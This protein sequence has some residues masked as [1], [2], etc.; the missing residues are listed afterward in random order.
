MPKRLEHVT[1]D[2][3]GFEHKRMMDILFGIKKDE[4]LPPIEIEIADPGQRKYRLR[5]GF[6]RF[7]ASFD[8][9][10]THIPCDEVPRL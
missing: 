5:D 8:L 6:H 2:A 4:S 1:K 10:F 3:N 7:Y 9:K